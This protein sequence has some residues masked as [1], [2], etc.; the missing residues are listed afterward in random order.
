MS[1]S[2]W[3]SYDLNENNYCLDI[4]K[5]F[6]FYNDFRK[7]LDIFDFA[8][9]DYTMHHFDSKHYTIDEPEMTK[10][11]LTVRLDFGRA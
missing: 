3:K 7:Y 9:L 11:G 8:L 5:R 4:P 6:P 2:S 10:T 1:L